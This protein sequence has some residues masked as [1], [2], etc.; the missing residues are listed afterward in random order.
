MNKQI[1]DK[2]DLFLAGLQGRYEDGKDFF[3]FAKADFIS[4]RKTYSLK[5]ERTGD[6]LSYYFMGNSYQTDFAD[7]RVFLKN[8]IPEFDEMHF[9]YSERGKNISIHADGQ[10]VV[11]ESRDQAAE[12]IS[13]G[14]PVMSDREYYIKPEKAAPLLKEIGILGKNGKIR[15][16]KIRKYNQIDH[17]IELAD[18]MLRRIGANKKN[19][20][21]ID[22]GC[23]KSYLSFALNFYLKEVLGKNCYFTGLDR[24]AGVIGESRQIAQRLRYS[25]MKF[26]ETDIGA[27]EPDAQYDMLLTLHACDTATDKALTFALKHKIPAII[28]VPCCHKELNAQ[29]HIDGFEDL[30]KYGILRARIAD[31]LTDGLRAMYLEGHGYDV[32][33]LEYISPVDTPKNLMIKAIRTSGKNDA[34]LNRYRNICDFL[35]ADLSIGK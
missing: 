15:N 35:G 7:F 21:M 27:Y 14:T 12:T 29:Y 31:N 6:L 2:T 32:S 34:I 3:L 30:L 13:A 28:C 33:M 4:G 10:N 1:A 11:S 23:G 22:C 16:D 26:I 25:N 9:T 8:Q 5:A 18:P 17:F 20:R 24:N 19:I